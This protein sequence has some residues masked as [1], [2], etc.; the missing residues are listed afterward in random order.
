MSKTTKTPTTTTRTKKAEWAHIQQIIAKAAADTGGANGNGMIPSGLGVGKGLLSGMGKSAPKAPSTPAATPQKPAVEPIPANVPPP[1]PQVPPASGLPP[2]QPMA[3]AQPR[4]AYTPPPPPDLTEYYDQIGIPRTPTAS[5]GTVGA[6]TGQISGHPAG[7]P[8]AQEQAGQPVTA[9]NEPVKQPVTTPADSAPDLTSYYDQ[10][11]ASSDPKTA[12]NDALQ[13]PNTPPEIKQ[14]ILVD[15]KDKIV[16]P[17]Q[18]NFAAEVQAGKPEAVEKAK[19]NSEQAQAQTAQEYAAQKQQENP[20]AGPQDFGQWLSEGWNH[21][22]TTFQNMDPASQLLVGIGLP[23]GLVGILSSLFGEGGATGGIL[24]ALGL[25]AA[26]LAAT[27]S[28]MF[29]NDARAALGNFAADTANFF[30][31]APDASAFTPEGM[32]KGQ[33]E[34][35]AAVRAA[36]DKAK[37]E[38]GNP[39][40]AGQQAFNKAKAPLD[41]LSMLGPEAGTTMLMGVLKTKDPAVARVKYDELMKMR[42][43]FSAPDYLRNQALQAARQRAKEEQGKWNMDWAISDDWANSRAEQTLDQMYPGYKPAA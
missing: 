14:R 38:G 19:A 20:N 11:E 2:A 35:Q 26:G 39:W 24:G 36:M 17:D 25:G 33:E 12:I 27:N 18:K 10:I 30:G 42:E 29:G 34:G 22:S 4:P 31:A 1:P 41:N 13:D 21:A 6:Q 15:H 7:S 23:L 16:S 43:Q 32:A 40:E 8:S 3:Q 37:A 5:P 28:G 9:Q